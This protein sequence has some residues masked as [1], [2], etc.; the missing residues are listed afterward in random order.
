MD[1][2]T[3][4]VHVEVDE[5]RVP[6]TISWNASDTTAENVQQAKAMILSFWDGSEKT[7]LRIDLWT[8]TMM[9][10]EMSD[11]F[12][13]TIITMADSYRRATNQNEIADDMKQYARDFYG[14][15]KAQQLKENK[16]T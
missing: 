1:K 13:Q 12:Y 4:T 2:S 14:K 15:F 8:K 10:D 16:T 5:N 11:F 3:I 7:A 9:V 6:Q